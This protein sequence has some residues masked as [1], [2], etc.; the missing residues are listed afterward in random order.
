MAL[1][2]EHVHDALPDRLA[3]E[4][5]PDGNHLSECDAARVQRLHSLLQTVRCWQRIGA[6][7][8]HARTAKVARVSCRSVIPHSGSLVQHGGAST[9]SFWNR[10]AA[11]TQDFCLHS[12]D[13]GNVDLAIRPLFH[14]ANIP[15]RGQQR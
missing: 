8:D 14:D 10:D 2:F 4:S 11:L 1:H 7:M 5:L 12:E 6:Q 9:E 13:V 3:L 15:H